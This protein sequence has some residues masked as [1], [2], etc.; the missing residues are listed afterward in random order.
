MKEELELQLVKDF[1]TFF[2]DYKGD[3]KATCMAWGIEHGDGWYKIFHEL[4][5]KVAGYISLLTKLRGYGE[6]VDIPDF[7]WTQVKEKFGT[8]RWYYQGGDDIIDDLVSNSEQL[9]SGTCE[10]C[11]EWGQ[12]RGKFWLY[13]ACDEHT[14]PEDLKNGGEVEPEYKDNPYLSIIKKDEE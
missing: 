8:A 7:Y 1:P 14:K 11:G 10:T 12:V 2:R 9:T 13:C 5:S 6:V 3:P 4:N